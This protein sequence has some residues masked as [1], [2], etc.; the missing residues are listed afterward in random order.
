M[1]KTPPGSEDLELGCPVR[2]PEG[3]ERATLILNQKQDSI[4]TIAG[5]WRESV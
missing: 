5:S 1:I 4:L 3:S 2:M